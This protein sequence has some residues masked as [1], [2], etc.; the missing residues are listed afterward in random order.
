MIKIPGDDI[1]LK[2]NKKVI[3]DKCLDLIGLIILST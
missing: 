1:I 3:G 2:Q